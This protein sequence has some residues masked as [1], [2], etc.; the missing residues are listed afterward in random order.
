[1]SDEAQYSLCELATR[2]VMYPCPLNPA[3]VGRVSQTRVPTK[4]S[5]K[6]RGFTG[7]DSRKA[8]FHQ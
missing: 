3:D 5:S 7:D 1:M 2:L 6:A 8:A 4:P